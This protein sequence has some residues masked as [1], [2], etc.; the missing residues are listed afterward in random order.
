M[1]EQ[2]ISFVFED[3]L[4]PALYDLRVYERECPYSMTVNPGIRQESLATQSSSSSSEGSDTTSAISPLPQLKVTDKVASKITPCNNDVTAD[5]LIKD[6]LCFDLRRRTVFSSGTFGGIWIMSQSSENQV[7]NFE[8]RPR[9]GATQ[10][11]PSLSGWMPMLPVTGPANLEP[12]QS[13]P[14]T[15]ADRAKASYQVDTR[16][17]L[18]DDRVILPRIDAGSID[19]DLTMVILLYMPNHSLMACGCLSPPL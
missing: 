7:D 11:D 1:D 2:E 9:V 17:T 16:L 5:V 4:N 13:A 8:L 15:L 12:T 19:P 3:R 14:P 6:I 10:V 18:P